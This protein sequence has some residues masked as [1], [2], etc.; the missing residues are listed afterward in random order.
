MYITL[1]ELAE[2][3]DLPMEYILKQHAAGAIKAIYTGEDFVV[4]KSDFD[5]YKEQLD[6][7]RKQI[8]EELNEPIPEDWDAKDED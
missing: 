4:S 3:L 8:Y 7:K 2:Y 6:L 1:S 5:W